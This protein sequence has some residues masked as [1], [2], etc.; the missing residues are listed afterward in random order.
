MTIRYYAI[1][2]ENHPGPLAIVRAIE[3]ADWRDPAGPT[4][5]ALDV[6]VLKGARPGAEPLF[7]REIPGWMAEQIYHLHRDLPHFGLALLAVTNPR[8]DD[9]MPGRRKMRL[10]A[11]DSAE[12]AAWAMVEPVA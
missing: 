5:A 12:K 4:G 1:L 8:L 10:M 9:E 7:A 6:I 11:L 2:D 3:A